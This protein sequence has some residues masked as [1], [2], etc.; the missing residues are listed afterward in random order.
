MLLDFIQMRAGRARQSVWGGVLGGCLLL[1]PL[2]AA[3][4]DWFAD[5][6]ETG[7]L[8]AEDSPAGRWDDAVPVSPNTLAS[9]T[10]GAHRG[11]YGFT[12]V[13]RA[14]VSGSQASINAQRAPLSSEFHMRSWL[15]MRAVGTE[16]NVVLMQGLPALVELR[17]VLLPELRW[18]LAAR[19]GSGRTY[20]SLHGSEVEAERWYL[21]EFGVR[22]LGTTSG[23]ARLWVDGIE[24]GTALTGRDF[25]DAANVL[26]QVMVGEP[27]SD[28][29]TFTGSLD[30]D[31]VR[32]SAAP[33]ASRLEL[34]QPVAASGSSK[35]IAVDVSL[36]TSANGALAPAPYD[37]EVAL[38]SNGGAGDFHEDADCGSPVTR[39]VL[40]TGVSE[41]RVYFRPTGPEGAV[42]LAASHADFLPTSLAV[43]PSNV[44]PSDGDDD[45]GGPW[46]CA[47]APG[48]FGALPLLLGAWLWRVRRPRAR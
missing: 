14:G 33:M 31:D 23:E 24:Q 48:A 28:T 9:G 18:E 30:F 44:L 37:A 4:S 26:D 21:V 11:R 38:A 42:T 8:V 36:R 15:R 7:T 20:V 5:D 39:L 32:V 25:R 6:F 17:L 10:A 40:P 22:G 34:R 19:N 16:G 1:S 46:T 2:P 41:H 12:V 47:S 43:E 13:D 45:G 27:W 3:A 29:G 35:C